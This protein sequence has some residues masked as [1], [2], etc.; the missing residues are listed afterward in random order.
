MLVAALQYGVMITI[1]FTEEEQAE[2]ER[3][4][5]SHPHSKVQRKMEAL[6]LKSH[7]LPHQLICQ[8]CQIEE[9]TL[10]RYL[11]AYER[12]GVEALQSLGYKGRP[13]RLTPHEVSLKSHFEQHPPHSVSQAQKMIEELTGVHRGLTQVR[14]FLHGLKMKYRKT[15][16]VPGK[17][18][19]PEKQAEQE[20]FL[21]KNSN[22]PWPKPKRESGWCFP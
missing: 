2:L 21:K 16:F 14:G 11:R 20:D 1:R 15:G 22:R 8:I 17:A 4:R 7:A 10:V 18:D 6:Y 13:N 9:P 19:H 12:G 3:H 5:Y